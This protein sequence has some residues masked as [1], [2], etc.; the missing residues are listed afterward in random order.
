MMVNSAATAPQDS[1][2]FLLGSDQQ[3]VAIDSK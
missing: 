1:H 3:I 2:G